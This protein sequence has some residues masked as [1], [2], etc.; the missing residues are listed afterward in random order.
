MSPTKSDH[1]AAT[2]PPCIASTASGLTNPEPTTVT[3]V[4][5]EADDGLRTEIVVGST[6]NET[7]LNPVAPMVCNPLLADV[8]TLNETWLVETVGHACA[9]PVGVATLTPSNVI[10]AGATVPKYVTVTVDPL[11]PDNADAPIMLPVVVIVMIVDME[12]VPSLTVIEYEP[13]AAGVLAWSVAMTN[14]P[15]A[16]VEILPVVVE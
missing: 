5:T 6:V 11:A 4:P 15:L 12:F 10:A 14:A 8:G 1:V 9:A 3:T 2:G 16:S 7:E 13:A